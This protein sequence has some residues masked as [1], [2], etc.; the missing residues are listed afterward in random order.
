[1]NIFHKISERPSVLR[2]SN[3]K[4]RMCLTGKK[5]YIE[6]E[7]D[8]EELTGS[9]KYIEIQQDI[10][11]V[12]RASNI[13][14]PCVQL[15]D[16]RTLN[17]LN[18]EMRLVKHKR[19][20]IPRKHKIK[21]AFDLLMD[22]L[23]GYSV[24]SS[25]YFLAFAGKSSLTKEFDLFVWV[26]FVLDLSLNFFTEYRNRAK[27]DVSNIKLI[28]IHYAKKW[29]IFDIASLL[30]LSWFGNPNVEYFLRLFR[31]FKLNRLAKRVNIYS[32]A[33]RIANLFYTEETKNKKI[34][35]AQVCLYWDLI[36]ELLKMLFAT[37]CIACIW[38]YYTDLIARRE[39]E[40]RGFITYF[41]LENLSIVDQLI[42]TWYFIFST[43]MTVG[44]GDFFATNKYEMLLSILIVIIGPTW[45]AFTMGKAINLINNLKKI[46]G[47]ADNLSALNIWVSNVE[48][49]KGLM[50]HELR[51]KILAHFLHY[52][53]NDRLESMANFSE[54]NVDQL[55]STSHAFLGSLPQPVR[56]N[57][58]E[59][60]F[61]D[62]F[63]KF[64][65]F[66]RNFKEIQF[67][68]A[69]FIQPRIYQEDCV[70][71]EQNEMAHE[72]FL[73]TKG[74]LQIRSFYQGEY[75]KL[76]TIEEI[77]IVGDYFAFKNMPSFAQ[78]KAESTAH[79]Y[80][81]PVFAIK[82]LSSMYPQSLEKQLAFSSRFYSHFQELVI[83]RTNSRP[84]ET[85][86]KEELTEVSSTNFFSKCFDVPEEHSSRIITRITKSIDCLKD[87]RKKLISDL[88]YKLSEH[89]LQDHKK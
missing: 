63:Y 29:L 65:F 84:V 23:I 47:K 59:F 43:L 88:K 83:E 27:L 73:K 81:I 21:K 64:N 20:V 17:A 13:D 74:S 8:H 22:F 31:I 11:G 9:A 42:R 78:F 82:N 75:V 32:V 48:N 87:V 41:D 16:L 7:S 26:M 70:I 66:F 89:I 60:L 79:G 30:P 46:D 1:M 5:M 55:D 18:E 36:K 39:H 50:P 6:T 34:L 28:T 58:I 33:K 25:L 12:G 2:Y 54:E 40:A 69:L 62:I 44:Y 14:G 45:F 72:I 49:Q 80:S 86:D 38:R 10:K 67:K 85:V 77:F 53:K 19:F 76:F 52:W 35:R 3:A 71:L 61:S 57:I 68:I 15:M 56:E 51:E 37:Y 24:I 4:K